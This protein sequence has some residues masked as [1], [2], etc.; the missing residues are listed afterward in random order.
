[1]TKKPSTFAALYDLDKEK[2]KKDQQ[3]I[4]D[5]SMASQE[6]AKASQNSNPQLAND[7]QLAII[8]A[9]QLANSLASHTYDNS[10][11]QAMVKTASHIDTMLASRT[12]D[13]LASQ[14]KSRPGKVLFG[15]RIGAELAVDIKEFCE[16]H[17]FQIQ[18]FFELAASHFM[19]FVAS[20]NSASQLANNM[21]S[22]LANQPATRLAHDDLKIFK[23]H[24]DIIM[25]YKELTGRRWA[26]ADDRVGYSVREID[27]RII[28]IA[29]FQT[30]I[31]SKGKR[32]HSFNYFMPEIQFWAE[33]IGQSMELDTILRRMKE[34]YQQW[35]G[36]KPAG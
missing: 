34:K 17:R 1:M 22:Q 23:T 2:N 19:T 7:S 24:E 27:R 8:P 33:S 20:Q 32:I 28:Q 6:V 36:D 35:K 4:E 13:L 12:A 18:D 3:K 29:M 15:V 11:S 16:T 31:N 21:A 30:K 26:P 9:S 14:P 5:Q 25:L 10:A